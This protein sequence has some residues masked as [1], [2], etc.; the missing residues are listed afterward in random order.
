MRSKIRLNLF[1]LISAV[2]LVAVALPVRRIKAASSQEGGSFTVAQVTS[3]PFPAEMAAAPTGE[4]IAWVFNEKGVRNIWAAE[5]PDFKAHQVTSYNKDDGQELTNLTFS[6]D[7]STIVFVRG[8]DH[9][10][11]WQ[12]ALEPDP[13]SS[14][15]QPK[16]QVWAVPFEGGTPKLLADGDTPQVNPRDGRVAFV[17]NHQIWAVPIDGSKKAE[18][19]FFTRGQDDNPVW[20]PDGSTIACVSE[21]EGDHAFIALYRSDSQPIQYLAPSTSM[22]GGPQ[23]SPDGSQI[24]FVRMPG[25]GGAPESLLKQ[26][27][28]PWKIMVADVSTGEAHAAWQSPDTLLGSFPQTAGQD[29]LHWAAG[30]RLIFLCDLDNWPHVYSVPASGGEAMLLTPGNFM[31]EYVTITPDLKYVIYNANTGTDKDDDDRRHLFRVPVDSASPVAL[32]SGDTLEHMPVITGDSKFVGYIGS[33]PKKPMLPGVIP[34]EGGSQKYLAEDQVPSDFPSNDLVVPRKVVVTADDGVKVHCQL[35]EAAGGPS[36]KPAVIFV[37]GGP[38]RQMLL[39]W[40]YMDYY[41]NGYAVNQYLANH[42]YIVL[43]VNYRLGI[44][45]GHNFH[46]PAHSGYRGADEYKDVVAGAHFLQQYPAVDTKRI[47]I[48][49]GS[50]GGYLTAMALARNSDI[51][52]TGVDLHGVHDWSVYVKQGVLENES[53][54][55]KDD[56][57]EALKVAWESSPVATISKWKS[58]VLLIQGDDDRN[59][60]FHQTV[61]LARRLDKQGVNYEEMILPDEIHGFLRHKTWLDVDSATVAYFNRQ[62]GVQSGAAG[63]K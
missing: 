9:D 50:Y 43:S 46:H 48:W 10:S 8:G 62:F 61:D 36:K 12:L 52:A 13:D 63:M 49:G 19:L 29:N 41:T 37:H 20:S 2:A 23:W 55:E 28:Q 7:G 47:G 3:Y 51:F 38:P 45:Y 30:N 59:V 54:Y 31:D 56:A 35:F 15:I 44:G 4:R 5:G 21:R 39:G 32:T 1:L 11:N 24:A 58:P 33:G 57:T 26:H 18:R 25:R 22:D 42:G 16:R 60:H 14:P 34:V 27:P 17:T 40:H 53:R 6:H